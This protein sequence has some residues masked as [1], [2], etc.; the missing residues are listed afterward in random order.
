MHTDASWIGIHA[1]T[2]CVRSVPMEQS[3]WKEQTPFEF[4]CMRTIWINMN[5]FSLAFYF[6]CF[7]LVPPYT[8]SNIGHVLNV[9]GSLIVTE[10]T[11]L[12]L[13]FGKCGYYFAQTTIT[14]PEDLLPLFLCYVYCVS[15][16][17]IFRSFGHFWKILRKKWN[18]K[19]VVQI[20]YSKRRTEPFETRLN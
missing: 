20:H 7:M 16:C 15:K 8:S 18:I 12:P 14:H 10:S 4:E 6:S 11:V 13:V 17:F 19:T 9:Q 5:P 1:G 2:P 3:T